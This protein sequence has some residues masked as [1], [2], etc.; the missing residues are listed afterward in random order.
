MNMD[1]QKKKTIK[2]PKMATS[3]QSSIETSMFAVL[4]VVISFSCCSSRVVSTS[5]IVNIPFSTFWYR[6]NFL[7]NKSYHSYY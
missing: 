5:L 4:K 6:L 3:G 2:I 1:F 7:E